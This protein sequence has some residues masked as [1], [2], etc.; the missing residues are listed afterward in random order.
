MNDLEKLGASAFGRL[1]GKAKSAAK[2][3][4]VR[5][6]AKKPRGKRVTVDKALEAKITRLK[7]KRD[8]L[9]ESSVVLTAEIKKL[10]NPNYT[11]RKRDELLESFFATFLG[12]RSDADLLESSSG[13]ILV[14]ARRKMF[15]GDLL[16]VVDCDQIETDDLKLEADLKPWIERLKARQ[17]SVNKPIST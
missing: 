15:K 11:P 2:T 6:N 8:A 3:K 12:R 7:R 17:Q 16:R 4:A 10:R 14:A 13:V 5:E 9:F 1:G